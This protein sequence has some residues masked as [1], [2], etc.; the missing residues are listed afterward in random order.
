[1]LDHLSRLG[2]TKECKVPDHLSCLDQRCEC[3][4]PDHL[5]AVIQ[6]LLFDNSHILSFQLNPAII[7]LNS[8]S[9]QYWTVDHIY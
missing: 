5:S 8:P 6:L 7:L 3:S 1:M 4:M 2:W 9:L